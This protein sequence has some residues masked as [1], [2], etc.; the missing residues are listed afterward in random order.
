MKYSLL[1]AFL[2]STTAFAQQPIP[3]DGIERP[4][5]GKINDSLGN[6]FRANETTLDDQTE[7]AITIYNNN[8]ALVKDRRKIPL[9]PGEITLQFMDVAQQ[10]NPATVSM[11][12]LSHPGALRILEQ[13]YEFDLI[14]YEKLMEK[15]VGKEVKLVNF[16]NQI[17]FHEKNATLMSYNQ[18]QPIYKID[19][20]IYLNHPGNVVFPEIPENLIAKPTL[21]WLL[22]NK[23][24]DQEIEVTYLTNGVSWRSDYVVVYDEK[25]GEMNL[26]SWI[27]LNNQSGT[28]Y[29]DA[30]LKLVAGEVN[31]VTNQSPF[32]SAKSVGR[33]MAMEMSDGVQEESFAEYH[34][35]T[36]PRKTT[37]KENQSKQINLFSAQDIKVQR[38]YEFRGQAHYY[39]QHIPQFG[40]EKIASYMVFKNK[41]EN[42]LGIPLPRGIIR[43]YQRD[44]SGALQ[45]SGEDQIKHTPKDETIRLKLGNAFD[46]VGERKHTHFNKIASN[47]I[48]STYEITI[49]NHK[50][51]DVVV[52]VVEPIT[53]DWQILE[54]SHTYKKEDARSAIFS[55][56]VK[57]DG[58]TK[59]SYRVRIQY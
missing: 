23:E 11:R 45:F 21:V 33:S 4:S 6:S 39:S 20:Q 55:L 24:T 5:V 57:A 34:L 1:C 13:N 3:L 47:V 49:R 41:K 35:Y 12:S 8:L 25:K 7:V 58:E 54:S 38:V 10:I 40:P 51:T 19:D 56:P 37:I 28:A 27:T 53:G 46:V 50:E 2:I 52:D 16:S 44:N 31:I 29:T 14:N 59:L 30:T 17:G 43:V 26:D 18:G 48:E 22:D 36:V 15:Y 42:E 32:P 9:F